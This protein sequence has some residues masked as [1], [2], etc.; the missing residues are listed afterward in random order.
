MQ[1][2][3]LHLCR[4]LALLLLDAVAGTSVSLGRRPVVSGNTSLI[5]TLQAKASAVA[6]KYAG[7]LSSTPDETPSRRVSLINLQDI[8]YFTTISVG[9]NNQNFLVN[10]DTGSAVFW[11]P[12]L[13]CFSCPPEGQFF[14]PA[15]SSSYTVLDATPAILSYGLGSVEGYFASD[16]ARFAGLTAVSQPVFMVTAEDSDMLNEMEIGGDGI[17]GLA[18]SGGLIQP[19]ILSTE[20]PTI[21]ANLAS[22]GL[23]NNNYFCLWFNQSSVI[24]NFQ[25]S[26]P[27]GGI[28]SVGI[29]D[30]TLYSGSFDFFP[31]VS[32]PM[33]NSDGTTENA[34]FFWAVNVASASFGTVALAG[35]SGLQVVIDSGSTLIA[36][37]SSTLSSILLELSSVTTLRDFGN[38]I[39]VVSCSN[40]ADLPSF[41]FSFGS[42]G[43]SFSLS[44]S[45]YIFKDD[46]YCALGITALPSGTF[47]STW[48]FGDV[49][50]KKYF[51]V[52]DY[53]NKQV[54]FAL[55]SDGLTPGNGVA[56]T[57]AILSAGGT[58]SPTSASA[59]S[60]GGSSSA[61]S[62]SANTRT[63]A[64]AGSVEGIAL[65][66]A[67]LVAC[68]L[69]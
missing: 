46:Q 63:S 5:E 21:L 58:S 55:A 14:N 54:G 22:E 62:A 68:M 64:T 31:I 43:S 44:H 18:Y 65:G 32:I 11:I 57:S 53:G 29:A 33:M 40:V 15:P 37:D 24:S 51:T 45:D 39:Y 42:G 20:S 26:D 30:T 36:V 59:S 2:I 48:I 28:L 41:S 1:L 34:L 61:K 23:L 27:N 16:T 12:V 9:S 49:F 52:F 35:P 13:G 66:V 38:G 50:M 69:L 25:S 3:R 19:G 4:I 67:V 8:G 17:L 6:A 47:T 60:A 7:I 56:L 10:I